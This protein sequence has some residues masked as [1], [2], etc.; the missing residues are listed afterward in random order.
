MYFFFHLYSQSVFFFFS[1]SL[2][3]C[4]EVL[5]VN[6][7]CCDSFRRAEKGLIHTYTCFHSPQ[8]SLQFR[9]PRNTKQSSTCYIICP[10][11][12]SILNIAGI[13][14]LFTWSDSLELEGS[15]C[16]ESPPPFHFPSPPVET[17]LG[18]FDFKGREDLP[19]CDELGRCTCESRVS[20][21][22]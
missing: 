20:L 5:P 8:T 2:L 3:F 6:T 21:P 18:S 14:T 15:G 1:P 17:L 9:L 16:V 12:L 19:G 13:H 11:L 7:Q 4:V 10:C 22:T